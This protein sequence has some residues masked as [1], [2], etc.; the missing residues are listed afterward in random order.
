MSETKVMS[1]D[2]LSEASSEQ[3]SR[4]S[5]QP[6][7]DG[8]IKP[9]KT[10][11][12][13][14]IM[15]YLPKINEKPLRV[16]L[17]DYKKGT[18]IFGKERCINGLNVPAVNSIVNGEQTVVETNWKGVCPLCEAE[19]L[20]WELANAKI[21]FELKQKGLTRATAPE[22]VLKEAQRRY[23]GDRK[24]E[25]PTDYVIFPV[26]KV[27]VNL[28]TLERL[29]GTE[30]DV[31]YAMFR[32]SR[33]L[34]K[35]QKATDNLIGSD[36]KDPFGLF[37]VWDFTYDTKG[38]Q[39][40]AMLSAKNAKYHIM[41]NQ[42]ALNKLTP[43]EDEL[44][45]AAEKYTNAYLSATIVDIMPK[46]VDVFE[47]LAKSIIDASKSE[48]AAI[49]T[50]MST[51]DAPAKTPQGE[52]AAALEKYVAQTGIESGNGNKAGASDFLPN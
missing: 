32:E 4:G 31:S 48:L 27:P 36:Q 18:K 24:V 51:L 29:P 9:F 19:S 7:T 25:S 22:E 33:Y 30:I 46:N 2:E 38:S 12:N 45:K 14:A 13:E 15:V 3:A 28:K 50:A 37:W 20:E 1:L 52:N 5:Y 49:N 16:R 10:P 42:A 40:T 6:T 34:D 39:P 21:D 11:V 35:L 44:T 23:Y 47:Q 8:D 17:H 41:E 26:V 43:L